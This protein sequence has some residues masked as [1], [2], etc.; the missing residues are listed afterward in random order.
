MIFEVVR[1]TES[2][3]LLLAYRA[4]GVDHPQHPWQR[5]AY[6]VADYRLHAGE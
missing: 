3:A 5:S 6:E 1:D 2:R 4:F